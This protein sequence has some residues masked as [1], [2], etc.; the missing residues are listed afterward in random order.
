MPMVQ[1]LENSASSPNYWVEATSACQM[2]GA[3]R[4][5]ETICAP[6]AVAKVFLTA[7]LSGCTL[8]P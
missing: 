4:K 6:V 8:E 2:Q 1:A 5:D 7:A 3:L